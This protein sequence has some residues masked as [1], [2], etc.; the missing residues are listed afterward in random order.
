L[1][2]K[3]ILVV[4]DEA[5]VRE[6]IRDWLNEAG[7]Q[8]ETAETG[9]EALGMI[10]KKDFGIMILD[11]RLPG[12]S[13]VDVLREMK[14]TKPQ[15]KC[16]VITAFPSAKLTA[17]LRDLGTLD[18]FLIKPMMMKDLEKLVRENMAKFESGE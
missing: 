3:P 1:A 18:D 11:Y 7:Y 4:D 9:E 12:R 10:E 6:S 13:G 16:I 15:T 17:E 5:I 2:M 14:A 8:A